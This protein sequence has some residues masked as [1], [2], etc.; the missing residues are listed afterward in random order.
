MVVLNLL[1]SHN[2]KEPPEPAMSVS[3]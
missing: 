1:H 3:G 2:P